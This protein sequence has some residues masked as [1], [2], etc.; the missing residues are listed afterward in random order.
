MGKLPEA[1]GWLAIAFILLT[2]AGYGFT[3]RDNV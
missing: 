2:I 1:N 3:V